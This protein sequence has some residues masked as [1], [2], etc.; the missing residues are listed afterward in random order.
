MKVLIIA[1]I[2]LT[3]SLSLRENI[4]KMI[5]LFIDKFYTEKNYLRYIIQSLLILFLGI[6]VII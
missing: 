6:F 2:T 3:I 5:G 1:A 4:E